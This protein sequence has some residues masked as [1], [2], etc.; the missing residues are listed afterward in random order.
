NLV[1]NAAQHN[2]PGGWIDVATDTGEGRAII[3]VTNT[4]PVIPAG[5]L[6][7]LFQPFQRLDAGRTAGTNGHLGLGLSI[8][9]AIAAAHAAELTAH[10]RPE[11]GLQVAVRFP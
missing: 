11:G 4:G 10:P 1:D 3:T 5:E 8:V 6:D 9:Q 2:V 7:R